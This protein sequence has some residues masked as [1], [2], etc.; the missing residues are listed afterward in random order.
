VRFVQNGWSVKQLV[1]EMVMSATY[2]QSSTGSAANAQ[3]DEANENLWRMER[4]RLGI[5]GY[6]DAMMSVA[7]TLNLA[8]GPSQDVRTAA[9]GKRTLYSPVS[10]REL[11]KTLALFDY[12]DANVHAARRSGS[13]TPTQKL[14]VMNSPFVIGQARELAKRLEAQAR[15]EAGRVRMAYAMLFAREPGDD[16]MRLARE[17]LS[18]A[19]REANA[20]FDGWEQ[21]CQAL[22][23]TNEMLYVD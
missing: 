6:R 13:I 3:L 17:F 23:A 14:F 16:E 7:G 8:G 21:L 2:R 4:R 15:D 12:P 19:G 5:E 22:L 20:G 10:R 9:G 11:N 1:R 18:E